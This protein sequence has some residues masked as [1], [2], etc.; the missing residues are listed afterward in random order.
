MVAGRVDIG[1]LGAT[2]FVVG[3][4]KG[5]VVA[6][7][8]AMYAGKTLSV[9]A[10]VNSGITDVSQLKGKKVGSQVGSATDSVFQNKILPAYGLS[11]S[12]VIIVNIP[13]LNAIAASGS[14]DAFAGVEPIPRS[15]R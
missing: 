13:H 2:P 3:A 6:I 11:P 1:V 4:A 5:E 12:D 8:M 10:G 14:I 9:V 15:P 7:G